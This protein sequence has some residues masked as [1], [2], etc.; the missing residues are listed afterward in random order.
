MVVCV[1]SIAS[2]ISPEGLRKKNMYPILSDVICAGILRRGRSISCIFVCFCYPYIVA[3]VV[4]GI[5]VTAWSVLVSFV[6]VGVAGDAVVVVSLL[7]V[8]G[9]TALNS[10]S[11]STVQHLSYCFSNFSMSAYIF[12]RNVI[13]LISCIWHHE[14]LECC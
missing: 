5:V 9:D 11:K 1:E 6:V 14:G 4:V 7:V 3:G 8:C 10:K 12:G 13:H 2:S